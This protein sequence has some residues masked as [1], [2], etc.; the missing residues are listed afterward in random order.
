M[1]NIECSLNILEQNE[2]IKIANIYYRS[3]KDTYI[4]AKKNNIINRKRKRI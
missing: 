1:N 4:K 3:E 2:Y